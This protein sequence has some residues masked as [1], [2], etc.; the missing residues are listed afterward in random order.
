MVFPE[1]ILD[2]HR[3]NYSSYIAVEKD[4]MRGWQVTPQQN[5]APLDLQGFTAEFWSFGEGAERPYKSTC[6]ISNGK[7]NCPLTP[8]MLPVGRCSMQ[9]RITKAG[10]T[11]RFPAFK[12]YVTEA[13]D[14]VNP[15]G[16]A[17]E[18]SGRWDV[19]L[20]RIDQAEQSI[21]E[22]GQIASNIEA[23]RRKIEVAVQQVQQHADTAQSAVNTTNA[24]KEA[25]EQFAASAKAD[26]DEAKRRADN[27]L[28]SY[29]GAQHFA[30]T[31]E[32]AKRATEKIRDEL[33]TTVANAENATQ[34]AR[35]AA[36]EARNAM[37]GALVTT[38][39]KGLMSPEDKGKLDSVETGANRYQHPP[40]HKS[41][42][43]ENLDEHLA[44]SFVNAKGAHDL[45]LHPDTNTMQIW[46]YG[47]WIDF[48]PKTF[49]QDVGQI[50]N[51]SW[52][53]SSHGGYLL[54]ADI[55]KLT[56]LK[57]DVKTDLVSAINSV[58]SKSVLSATSE[59]SVRPSN[60]AKCATITLKPKS[61]YVV[62]GASSIKKAPSPD[63]LVYCK[64]YKNKNSASLT[65][66]GPVI[67]TAV[68]G[69]WTQSSAFIVTGN[70]TA[71][72]SVVVYNYAKTDVT[73]LTKIQAV[74]LGDNG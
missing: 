6:T 19:L 26:A 34:D 70:E 4:S 27:A 3:Q 69:S 54:R 23:D 22:A 14:N 16:G 64:I 47:S 55:G 2:L 25:T 15:G 46:A 43:V 48:K 39:K 61:V 65:P 37:D 72:A 1:I 67:G 5:G 42:E 73:Y 68:A 50:S 13:L 71:N 58:A 40:K 31:A 49:L 38:S 36:E 35:D 12:V 29:A 57:S 63:T 18:D 32:M 8:N 44:E 52:G 45:R 10:S 21:A 33:S 20:Q 53:L 11:L 56:N 9:L 30:N 60:D 51:R 74:R 41:S 7:I 24:N 59:N 66:D 62:I 17:G 28:G